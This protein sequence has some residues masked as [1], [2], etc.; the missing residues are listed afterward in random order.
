MKFE[1]GKPVY[2][3]YEARRGERLLGK[4]SRRDLPEFLE[5]LSAPCTIFK[6]VCASTR[7]G[8]R[9]RA[10]G[11]R[12]RSQIPP[13]QRKGAREGGAFRPNDEI[14]RR[15]P[16]PK[17]PRRRQSRYPQGG[18]GRRRNPRRARRRRP[19][20]LHKLFVGTR[21]QKFTRRSQRRDARDFK[22]IRI[23]RL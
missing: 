23:C 14:I 20:A 18:S 10:K 5:T 1:N 7:K 21:L 12:G 15:L 11:K 16:L 3:E 19:L 2:L 9:S 22:K 17:S 6:I 4:C 8:S 13:N